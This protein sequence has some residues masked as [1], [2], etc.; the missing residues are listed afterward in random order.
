MRRYT[1]ILSCTFADTDF[2]L[3]TT[4]KIAFLLRCRGPCD[5]FLE[6]TSLETFPGEILILHNNERSL[7]TFDGVPLRI[8]ERLKI[9]KPACISV[10]PGDTLFFCLIFTKR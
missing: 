3:K 1:R 6:P 4:G 10:R 9:S 5:T 7:P 2:Y 8:G